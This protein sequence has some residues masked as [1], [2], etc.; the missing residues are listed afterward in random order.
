M[1][2]RTMSKSKKS[3][4]NYCG[5]CD[6]AL[7]KG[8]GIQTSGRHFCSEPCR[9]VWLKTHETVT[10]KMI[11]NYKQVIDNLKRGIADVRANCK[12]NYEAHLHHLHT[13]DPE[14]SDTTN[15]KLHVQLYGHIYNKNKEKTMKTFERYKRHHQSELDDALFDKNIRPICLTL[16]DAGKDIGE[17]RLS[18]E[19]SLRVNAILIK[20]SIQSFELIIQQT[21][22]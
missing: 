19:E 1:H 13:C 8:E 15:L 18:G 4:V 17:T 3:V 22:P 5:F 21:F 9:N 14:I 11:K 6:V 10:E 12:A 20:L 2:K 16:A 7:Q